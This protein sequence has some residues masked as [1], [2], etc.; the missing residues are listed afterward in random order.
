MYGLRER[1]EA[2]EQEERV[3]WDLEHRECRRPPDERERAV[4]ERVCE[5]EEREEEE[6]IGRERRKGEGEEDEDL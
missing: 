6:G 1:I 4:Y 5:E 2:D 3:D